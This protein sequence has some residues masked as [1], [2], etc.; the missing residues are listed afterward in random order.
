MHLDSHGNTAHA[1]NNCRRNDGEHRTP[2]GNVGSPEP[3]WVE[4]ER[5]ENE[6]GCG[7]TDA[8]NGPTGDRC[9]LSEPVGQFTVAVSI[10][11]SRYCRNA[12]ERPL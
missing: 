1:D 2:P 8:H 9:D 10:D 11:L 7:L 4:R 3:V 6:M 12:T 5:A